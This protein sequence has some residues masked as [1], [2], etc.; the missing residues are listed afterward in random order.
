MN[1][2]KVFESPYLRASDFDD[3]PGKAVS[4]TFSGINLED[5]IDKGKPKRFPVAT[6]AHNVLCAMGTMW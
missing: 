4:L 5:F 2:L 3:L 1:I 6:W